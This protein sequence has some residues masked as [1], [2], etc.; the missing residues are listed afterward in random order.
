MDPSVTSV[1]RKAMWSSRRSSA[2]C[3]VLHHYIIDLLMLSLG[4]VVVAVAA[5]LIHLLQSS[6][7]LALL[8]LPLLFEEPFL[9]HVLL[10]G[11]HL[12]VVLFPF[13]IAWLRFYDLLSVAIAIRGTPI[14]PEHVIEFL[15]CLRV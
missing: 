4:S 8:F 10:H 2:S 6:H 5:L 9:F 14:S 12:A 11:H 13:D 15:A 7:L 3:D 1:S